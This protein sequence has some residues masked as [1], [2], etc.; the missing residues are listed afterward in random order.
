MLLYPLVALLVFEVFDCRSVGGDLAWWSNPYVICFED[1]HSGVAF[2]AAIATAGHLLGMP[3]VAFHEN[4]AWL[5]DLQAKQ[6]PSA[7]DEGAAAQQSPAT[8]KSSRD[9]LE[10][11][12][13]VQSVSDS[14]IEFP[15][16]ASLGTTPGVWPAGSLLTMSRMYHSC[17]WRWND[18]SCE[19]GLMHR[20]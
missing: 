4:R 3:A 16:Q 7:R 19:T 12:Q 20:A 9:A 13:V 2:M 8:P 1:T 10:T 18:S 14:A 15:V 11:A 6:S 17:W 5:N